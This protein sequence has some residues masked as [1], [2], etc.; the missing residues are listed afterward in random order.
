MA[1]PD[2]PM[3]IPHSIVRLMLL[4]FAL[5]SIEGRG[6]TSNLP[7]ADAIRVEAS[8][9]NSGPKGRP[10][11]L[12]GSWN[13]GT[14][15]HGYDP[16]YQIRLIEQGHHVL[17]WF[18]LDA[19]HG[20]KDI[21]NTIA[22]YR[23]AL[24]RCAALGLPVT[25]IS[26]QWEKLLTDDP[27]FLRLPPSLNP[28]VIRP[29]GSVAAMVSPFGP[30]GPWAEVGRQWTQSEA[31][32]QLQGWYPN[33]PKVVFISNNEQPKLAGKDAN[34][35]QRYVDRHGT[36][37]TDEAKR[38][39][40]GQG[41]VE[42][43]RAMQQGMRD[44]LSNANWKQN[45]IFVG[46]DAFG[47][48]AFGRWAGWSDNSLYISNRIAPWPL[49]WDGGSVSY[50]V[51]DWNPS[52]DYTVWSPQ[53]EAMN[54]VFMLE[55][56][57]RLNPN[58]WF[59]MSVWDGSQPNQPTDKRAFYAKLGQAYTP[60]RYAGMVKF[61][62][63]LLRPRSIREYRGS[64]QTLDD[65]QAYFENIVQAVDEL[66][67]NPVLTRFW[68]QGSLLSNTLHQ[69][70]YQAAIPAE[71]VAKPRWYLL[72]TSIDPKRPWTLATEIPIFALTLVTGKPPNREWLVFAFSPLR[73]YSKVTVSI[74]QHGNSLIDSSPSGRYCVINEPSN[75]C[76]PLSNIRTSD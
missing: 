35:D 2:K 70:P 74:P 28:N 65:T 43:Y 71:Y 48:A 13:T 24:L 51:N 19:P 56:A 23:K 57:Y 59:E 63:W 61:G 64:T 29:D 17:P 10:L 55:E 76:K 21:N 67:E 37:T 38:H 40:A 18:Q 50:Y 69:H 58:F 9:P 5:S 49:A 60:A 34:T 32:K 22:Y 30:V 27:N 42:R 25:F 26:S 8:L 52:T 53:I 7:V 3:L 45:A 72:D 39:T 54:W 20:W 16:D 66:Y 31:M 11:P 12:V 14:L 1:L 6:D 15:P 44:G 46:Y 41:W 47:D 33:P 73:E 75:Q 36:H 4:I 62:L 68:R